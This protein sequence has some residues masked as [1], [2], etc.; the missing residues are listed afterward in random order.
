MQV[1][2]VES[3]GKKRGPK[4]DAI[5]R[6]AIQADV[7]MAI[8]R[9]ESYR[10][11]A[12]RLNISPNTIMTY[13]REVEKDW[14][15]RATEKLDKVKSRELAKL[16]AI[17]KEAWSAWERSKESTTKEQMKAEFKLVADP[18]DPEKPRKPVR[19]P[20]E[21][22]T[23]REERIGDAK[24]LE[25]V[26]KCIEKRLRLLGVDS[27]HIEVAQ[28]DTDNPLQ[29]RVKRYLSVLATEDIVYAPGA[30]HLH[31]LGEPLDSQ[32]PSR[33]TGV[34]LDVDGLVGEATS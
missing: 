17:E 27:L 11:V 2:P 4:F 8:V 28:S 19:S 32:R 30:T 34:I 13:V 21:S 23:M 14:M 9:G 12:A 18:N 5:E 24:Y 1:V 15:E 22:R 25:I 10:E 6:S 7:A 3:V 20:K 29:T 33:E 26:F 31:S 16:D